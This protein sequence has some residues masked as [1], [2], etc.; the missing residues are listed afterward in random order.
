MTSRFHYSKAGEADIP[1]TCTLLSLAFGSPESGVAQ[2]VNLAGIE[3]MRVMR[4][5]TSTVAA[6]VLRIEMGQFFGGHAVPMLGI[7]GVSTAPEYRGDGLATTMMKH[8]V[9]EAHAEKWPLSTLYPS[10]QQLYRKAGYEVTGQRFEVAVPVNRL[11]ANISVVQGWTI[12]PLDVEPNERMKRISST[13]AQHWD[14]M[15]S[16]GG[17]VW[18]RVPRWRGAEYRAFGAFSPAGE[19]RGYLYMHQ[20]R[21]GDTGRFDIVLSDIAWDDVD[22]ARRMLMFMA[23]FTTMGD[24]L[25]FAAG[26]AHPLLGMIHH[27]VYRQYLKDPWMVRLTHVPLAIAS[28]GYAAA[29]E[30]KALLSVRDDVI[31]AHSQTWEIS[32]RDGVGSCVPGSGA[33][34]EIDIRALTQL[35]TGYRSAEQLIALGEVGGDVEQVRRLGAAFAGTTPWMTD[36]F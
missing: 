7:A 3:N 36:M 9:R 11:G 30:A 33:A 14:G 20:A 24:D 34:A 2:W 23:D 15:L 29:V 31:P 35:Y 1:R 13:F 17:Y 25:I 5:A 10:T 8:C 19:L 16:R 4:D 27:N 18:A 28:R 12:R 32:V 22:A 21:K 26:P 6:T